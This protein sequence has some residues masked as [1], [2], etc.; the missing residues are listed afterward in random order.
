MKILQSIASQSVSINGNIISKNVPVSLQLQVYFNLLLS[1]FYTIYNINK[2]YF[3][4][5]PN[6]RKRR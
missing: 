2:T 6:K 5:R 4:I 1:F 3:L